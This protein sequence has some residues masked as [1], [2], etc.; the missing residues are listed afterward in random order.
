MAPYALEQPHKADAVRCYHA[1]TYIVTARYQQLVAVPSLAVH[2]A[3]V[4]QTCK[5]H[6]SAA[7]LR[8]SVV[9]QS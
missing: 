2:V 9:I 6:H 1:L 3:K 8:D 4:L 5:M 7:W